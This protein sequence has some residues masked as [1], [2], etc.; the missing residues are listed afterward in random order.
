MITVS[1]NWVKRFRLTHRSVIAVTIAPNTWFMRNIVRM[2]TRTL[3]F[4]GFGHKWKQMRITTEPP[5]LH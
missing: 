4:E 3:Y 2:K 5:N 1:I